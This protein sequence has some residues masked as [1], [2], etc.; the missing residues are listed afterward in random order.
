MGWVG[1]NGRNEEARDE[2]DRM[3]TQG[4]DTQTQM[5]FVD[6]FTAQGAMVGYGPSMVL[7]KGTISRTN[8]QPHRIIV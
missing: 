1:W 2:M 4:L 5:L 7:R 6:E 8:G 3:M